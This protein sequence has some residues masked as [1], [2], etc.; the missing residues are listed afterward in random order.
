MNI[1]SQLPMLTALGGTCD[2]TNNA[3]CAMISNVVCSSST[4]TEGTCV[5][6]TGY[7]TDS[8][9]ISCTGNTSEV[10]VVIYTQ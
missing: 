5:C 10:L 2:S 3:N 7:M 6:N 8:D 9:G 1:C 4:A